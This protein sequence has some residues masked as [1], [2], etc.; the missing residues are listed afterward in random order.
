MFRDDNDKRINVFFLISNSVVD[1]MIFR[2]C[3]P[4]PIEV[5]SGK[6]TIENWLTSCNT[7]NYT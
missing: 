6:F 7:N 3:G 2:P 4:A 5:K 1:L